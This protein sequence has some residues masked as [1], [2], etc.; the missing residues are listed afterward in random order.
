MLK[1]SDSF[2]STPIVPRL[3][4]KYPLVFVLLNLALATIP[5]ETSSLVLVGAVPSGFT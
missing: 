1:I 5:L 4:P 2:L 3:I